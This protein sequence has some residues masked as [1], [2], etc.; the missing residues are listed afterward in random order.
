MNDLLA[1]FMYYVDKGALTEERLKRVIETASRRQ[2]GLMM[3]ME[4]VH[5]PHNLMAI[6]RSCD[7]FG[8]QDIGFIA[9]N[10]A[11]FNPH[12][13]GNVTSASASKW[14]DYRM[15][16]NGTVDALTTLKQEGYH[17]MATWVNPDAKS[18][19]EIDF[20][21]YDKL[22]LMVGNEHAGISQTAVDHADSYMYIPMQGMI[23]SF[24]VSVAAALSLFEVS[25]QRRES[26]KDF[27]LS[28]EALHALVS[29]F[30]VRAIKPKYYRR[31]K[32]KE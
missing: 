18:I 7:A 30:V 5:N 3:L 14:L 26:P 27:S 6:A 28:E 11:A 8:V 19:Y 22:V 10:E 29:D 12:E 13:I 16:E 15:F 23:E 25:R 9:D 21:A 17:I 4:D 20:A 24:N 32:G 2:S 1:E 31:L